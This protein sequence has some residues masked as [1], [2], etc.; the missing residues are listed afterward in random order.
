MRAYPVRKIVFTALLS[1][2][3]LI[4]FLIESLFPP[5]FIPGARL[6]IS[7][8]FVLFALITLG[9]KE[10]LAVLTIKILL[11]SIF[12]GNISAALYSLP[13]GIISFSLQ[14]LLV[15]FSKKISVISL[16]TLGGVVNLTV[17]NL[18]FCLIAGGSEYLIYLPYLAT[19][20]TLAGAFVGITV[21]LIVKIFP[22]KFITAENVADKV[23]EDE[24]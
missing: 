13:A 2:A 12:T 17:Q 22:Q 18:V 21:Y 16:S 6:G 9:V 19:I 11:G 14:A 23:G 10:G 20:G 3:A 7:N 8:V 5:L 1:A 24:I 4:S 15:V